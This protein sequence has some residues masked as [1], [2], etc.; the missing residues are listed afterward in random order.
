MAKPPLG[1]YEGAALKRA[2]GTTLA[3]QLRKRD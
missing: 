3:G 1:F 2:D